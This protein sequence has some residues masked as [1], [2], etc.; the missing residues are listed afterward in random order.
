M[1]IAFSFDIGHSSIGW[2]A[3]NVVN[4]DPEI[5][6]CGSVVFPAEDCQNQQRAAFRRQRRH[7]AAT[8]NRIKRLEQYLVQVGALSDAQL[9]ECRRNPHPWP[10][11]LAAQ[12]IVSNRE[13][14][15]PE[16]WSVIR[17]YAHNRGYDGNALWASEDADLDDV[18]KVQ[19][20]RKLMDKVGA[21]TMCETVCALLNA[22]PTNNENPSPKHYFKGEN[23][24]FPRSVVVEE[25]RRVVEAHIGK[26]PFVTQELILALFE[27][28]RA[29]ESQGLNAKLPERYFG[30]LLFGQMKPRFENRIIP[31]CRITGEKTPSKHSR[32]FYRYRWAMFMSNLRVADP[33]SGLPRPLDANECIQLNEI[34]LKLGFFT[35][36]TLRKALE[37]ELGLEPTNLDS[38]LL[39]PEMENA[40]TLDPAKREVLSNRVM[41]KIWPKIPG[42]WMPL[43]LNQLFAQR[44]YRGKPPS[45]AQW[46]ARLVADKQD[47]SL[48]DEAV[49]KAYEAELDQ[50]AKKNLSINMD[51]FMGRPI[52]L[53]TRHVASGRAPYSRAKLKEAVE[54]VV[55]GED[56]RSVGGPLEESIDVRT[57][58]R[59]AGIDQNSNNH[60]VRHRLK[61]Y[62]KTLSDLVDR[63][64]DGDWSRI[65]WVGIEV[66]RDL[67]QFSGKTA[68]EKALMLGAQLAHHRKAVKFLEN[69]REA[70]GGNWEISAGL[71]KKVRIADD[72]D[73]KCPFTGKTYSLNEIRNKSVDVEHIIPR[74]S[75]P[76]D[77]LHALT[78][79][80]SHINREKGART[81]LRYIEDTAEQSHTLSPKQYRELVGK[82]RKKNGPS[83]EDE[84]RCTKR[85]IALL[86]Q[87]YE[88]RGKGKNT[89][90]VESETVSAFTDG[91]LSQ[92]S[93][94]N[95]MAARQTS[96]W[97]AHRADSSDTLPPVIHLSGS[98]TAATRRTW[99]LL[100]AIY[101]ACPAAAGKNKTDIR[102]ITHLHHAL[103]AVVIGLSAHFFPRDGRL[104]SLMSR[105]RIGNEADKAYMREKLGDKIRFCADG[106][107]EIEELAP[108]L[109]EQIAKRL[110]EKRVVRHNPKTMRGLRVQQNVWRVEGEDPDDDSKMVISMRPRNEDGEKPAE[111]KRKS[112]R[113][114][115]LLGAFPEKEDS[116]LKA[117]KGALIVEDNYG[118]ALDPEPKVIP[119]RQVWKQLNDLRDLNDGRAVRV[120]RNGDVIEIE[121]GRYKGRWRVHS[122]KDANMGLVLDIASPELVKAQ[123]KME[124]C[125]LNVL[126]KS[127]MTGGL[128]VLD[129]DFSG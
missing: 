129:Q 77:A 61:V 76:T 117:L 46:R 108:S 22:D 57:K 67:V 104:W 56:P 109:K 100:G 52:Q 126:L 102:G 30:G 90:D 65:T 114:S 8:R 1:S 4:S 106:K 49:E 42:D 16:L 32:E 59:D 119:H 98:V 54:W 83:K 41:K 121:E 45:L 115:K 97:F 50:L 103:D 62:V 25:C 86:T 39:V 53:T 36:A 58:Q 68:K 38:M 6:G 94:L 80:F 11:Y 110:L 85:K 14:N 112:E 66:V 92:T 17:W 118:V 19:A 87:H 26:L 43:F 123:N 70:T 24:A 69:E 64:A 10:W 21:E 111:A 12:V 122:I 93:Y 78:L 116:K 105:R 37:K 127:L 128:R 7:I 75:R 74:S 40:L 5:L 28:W 35:K 88:K 120:M 2:A 82:L 107:W 84:S 79:T 51:E 31:K 91:S 63:Y 55:R 124:G 113:K 13:L 20:S 44:K 71:I 60:L 18:K 9:L 27:D 23:A 72:M 99:D 125:K 89:D 47:V 33:F 81:G 29:G 15:A 3:L 96:A 101:Q 95:K 34:M 73:W 48:F